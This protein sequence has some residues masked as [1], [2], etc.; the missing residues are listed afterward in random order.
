MDRR[1]FLQTAALS[2][3]AAVSTSSLASGQ[4]FQRMQERRQ[5]RRG[6][7]QPRAVE[8]KI[9]I[10]VQL[11]SVR[12][13]AQNDLPGTLE[14]IA[15][16][17]YEGVE[18]FGNQY[19]GRNGAELRKLLDDNG[20]KCCGTHT[21]IGELRGDNFPR[22]A[23][24]HL[25]LGTPFM[26]VPGTLNELQNLEG[27][28]RFVEEFN[29]IAERA[30]PLGL[31]TGYHAHAP[32]ARM[33]D[34]ITAWERFF[35]GTVHDVIHQM[36]T[37]N[38]KSG[39]GDPYAMIEKFA[40]RSRTVHLSETGQDRPVIGDGIVEWQRIFDL[41][42]TVGGVEWYVVEDAR[43]PDGFDRIERSIIAL[44]TMGK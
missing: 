30:K 19:Y 16:M 26:I 9:P 7:A 43:E 5:E 33:V 14:A 39:G 31:Y 40:G 23:E 28:Q 17:G 18:F 41:C 27:N 34:G 20:L 44:R 21:G 35:D 15:N 3:A 38:F 8:R 4:L 12:N 37:G 6:A 2:A 42:E 25:Q 24:L 32:D 29:Q 13:A 1:T 36:D 11:F 10:G 22:T